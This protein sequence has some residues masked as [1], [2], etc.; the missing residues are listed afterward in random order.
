MTNK[1][2]LILAI[3]GASGVIY[4]I[5]LLERLQHITSIRTHLILSPPAFTTI[6]QETDLQAEDVIALADEH[7][8]Y[9]NIGAPIASGSFPS[10]GMIVSPCSI[11]SLSSIASSHADNLITRAAD[12]QLKEGRPLLLMVRETPLHI[13]HLRLML[14]AAEIGAVIMPPIPAM[15]TRPSSLDELIDHTVTRTLQRFGL[16][17]PDAYQWEGTV[18]QN[19]K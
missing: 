19:S 2:N 11:K 15:Y 18:H 4:G 8:A 13:G 9:E 5:R 12:V 1:T 6:E 16:D 7:H 3:T 14:A 10:A 17:L